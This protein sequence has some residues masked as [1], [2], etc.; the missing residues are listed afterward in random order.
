MSA[1]SF[2]DSNQPHPYAAIIAA[3]IPGPSSDLSLI[4][5]VLKI[6]ACICS[7]SSFLA[8]PPI[9]IMVSIDLP[10]SLKISIVSFKENVIP[11]KTA[12]RS[13]EHTSELQSRAH[14]VC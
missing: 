6:S 13:E 9:D 8:P 1:H 5:L 4:T 10:L 2:K 7:Q 11:S 14:L 3:P 12:L